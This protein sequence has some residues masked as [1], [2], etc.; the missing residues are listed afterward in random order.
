MVSLDY[1]RS[2]LTQIGE[3][4]SSTTPQNLLYDLSSNFVIDTVFNIIPLTPPKR[5]HRFGSNSYRKLSLR[6]IDMTES[7]LHWS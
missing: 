2:L 1:T 4:Y 3:M 6:S 5:I 7:M